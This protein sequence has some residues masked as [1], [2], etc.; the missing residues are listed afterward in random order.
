MATERTVVET[1][2]L[3]QPMSL[4]RRA[5]LGLPS[6]P[7]AIWIALFIG[8]P[9]SFLL[10][11]SFLSYGF[12]DVGLPWTFKNYA[13]LVG[14]SNY[15]KLFLKTLIVAFVVSAGSIALASPYAYYTARVAGRRLALALLLLI[16]LPLW[17]NVVIR[18]FAWIG[19]VV[20]NGVINT[21]L[22]IIGLPPLDIIFTIEL[23]AIVGI[24]LALPFAVLVLYASMVN[25]SPEV[26][27]SS[28]DLGSG[29]VKTF[30][31]VIMPL[32][33]SGYQTAF[34]LIFMPTLA[35]FVTPM[36]LGGTE[37]VM[38]ATALMPI[39]RDALDFAQG[40]A[41]IVPI[42][43]ILITTVVIFRRGVDLDNLYRSGV[44]SSI[45]RRTDRG[46]PWLLA[47]CIAIL[48]LTYLPLLSMMG[49]SF[50]KNVSSV[51][52]LRG[53]TLEWYGYAVND[54]GMVLALKNSILIA[55]EVAVVAIAICA[56]AAY[57]VVRYPFPGRRAFLFV[58][59]LPMLIPELILGLAILILL[60][61]LN[62]HGGIHQIVVG[63]VTLA[64]PFVF[65]T[66][67]AQQYGFDR[68]MEEASRD[69]GASPRATFFKIVLPLMVPGLLAAAFLAIT[70]SFNDF[71]VAFILTAGDATFPLFILGQQKQ[72]S[73]PAVNAL[74]TLVF[75]GV[76]LVLVIA[77]VRPWAMVASGV[78]R[79]RLVQRT[80]GRQTAVESRT[81]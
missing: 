21:F 54:P 66:I 39:V 47:Y 46:N 75:V 10:I 44:G 25:I 5:T 1:R 4:V 9:A 13:K 29:R 34:L 58:S 68:A 57:A 72:G 7:L 73:S 80:R 59:L 6:L 14:A 53:F 62:I 48:F 17:M 49:F 2:Q 18:N 15:A 56:P 61:T 69:L 36:M 74:G 45:A 37:G 71:V 22:G 23:V 42:V 3:A 67:L 63:H 30:R 81:P 40:S 27:E 43:V 77:L 65:L 24:S 60:V 26:E 55:L 20:K 41:F 16:V 50:D 64:L 12:Y 19:L 38:I 78:R 35:F 32:S 79:A 76:A 31:K 11:Y 8:V 28:L 52:P 33:A 70:I 51:F